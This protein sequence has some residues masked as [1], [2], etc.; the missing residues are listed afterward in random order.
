MHHY[1]LRITTQHTRFFLVTNTS[2]NVI[3]LC[4]FAHMKGQTYK[5][6]RISR[7]KQ[8]SNDIWIINASPGHTSK[9]G[10]MLQEPSKELDVVSCVC[11]PLIILSPKSAIIIPFPIEELMPSRKDSRG[12]CIERSGGLAVTTEYCVGNRRVES[13][14]PI[15][16][17]L[18]SLQSPPWGSAASMMLSIMREVTTTDILGHSSA[19]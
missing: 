12:R 4:R 11:V 8:K 2:I 9:L 17:R 14:G 6:S 7:T 5:L 10:W 15:S 1:Q 16:E 3:K 13:L 18:S 19:D